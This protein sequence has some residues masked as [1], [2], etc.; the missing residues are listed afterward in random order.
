M[1]NKYFVIKAIC[2]KDIDIKLSTGNKEISKIIK[3]LNTDKFIYEFLSDL[4]FFIKI[5]N[6]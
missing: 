3:N 5:L 4:N 2:L 6:I 1:G